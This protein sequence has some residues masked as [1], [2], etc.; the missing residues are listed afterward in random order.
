MRYNQFSY[1]PTSPKKA[2]EELQ[3]LGFP[4]SLD[5]SEKAN[6]HTFLGQ[7]L[8]NHPDTAYPLSLWLAS[9]D[10]DALS[11]FQSD[12]PLTEEIFYLLALQVLEFVPQVDFS[13]PKE[14]LENIAF[15][16]TYGNIFQNLHQL[17]ASRTKTGNTL[18]DKLVSQGL[19]PIDNDYHYFNGKALATFDTNNLIREV[20]YVQAPVDTDQD[21]QLDLIKV[22][23]I[24]PHTIH[25]IPTMMTASPYH[26]GVN[27]VANDKKLHDMKQSLKVKASRH[28]KVETKKITR[29]ESKPKDL[30]TLPS[31]ES[32]SYIPSYTLNDYFLARGFANIYVSGVGTAGSDGFMT[33]G[34]YLQIESFKAVIDWLNGR[35]LAF[36]SHK[37]EAY[38]KADWS[39]GLV[40]T[41]GKSYLGTMS[42]GLATTGVEGLEVI[43][44]EAA[45]SSWY[46]YYRENGLICSPGGYPGEDLDVLTE[47][48]Y[49][50]S[51]LAGDYLRQK[52][53]YHS[54]L[55][56]QSQDIDRNSGD[57]NQYWHDRNYLPHADKV[58]CQLVFTHGL[59]DWNVKPN[60]VY[61]ILKALPDSL[62]THA[63][64]HHGQHVY[65]HNWQSIDFRESMNA[66]LC[67]KLLGQA[68][69]Y[70]LPSIIWQDNQV[71]QNWKVLDYFGS[72]KE[73]NLALGSGQKTID[74][75]YSAQD[76]QAYNQDFNLFKTD[77]YQ[78]KT[79]Q[80]HLDMT[81]DK[82]LPINGQI[83]LELCLKS[84][85]NKGILSAQLLDYKKKK[86]FADTPATLDLKTI[87]NGQN[88]SR[89]D[90]KELPYKLSDHRLITKGFINLQNRNDLLTIETI[91]AHQWM[92]FTLTLQPSIYQLEKGDHL[93]LILYTTD[94]EH[95]IR[96]NSEYHLSID[97]D[98]SR[99]IL[100]LDETMLSK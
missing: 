76:F 41:T 37:R 75:H 35:A 23:I 50:R 4:L 77:L 72:Q 63:F 26:Q 48:T 1:I 96:D 33:S 91:E 10:R 9:Q 53:K 36:T 11:F 25:K 34:D 18:I 13:N 8:K 47:L 7:I 70:Q 17:L 81:L 66:L 67:Q 88:F 57:Y 45:I 16:I 97:L 65:M 22:N 82:H 92:T 46:D 20:V 80:I 85:T 42:T 87:D 12:L 89:E 79:P 100:P 99:L 84:S 44:A 49:S 93:R 62:Q 83:K 51:L 21:G 56:Q 60:H 38:V 64:L 86:R 43:I 58:K 55:D 30:A 68:N 71:E 27:E 14:F 54:L 32:F 15:P 31:Q 90:L 98:K 61:K 3:T 39:N 2:L 40:A 74:N 73:L 94:F 6:L 29:L 28:I 59:Q 5:L 95:T 24:R 19:L 52:D 69:G 78:A